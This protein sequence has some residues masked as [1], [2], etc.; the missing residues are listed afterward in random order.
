MARFPAPEGELR[1]KFVRTARGG[2]CLMRRGEQRGFFGPPGEHA[3][4]AATSPPPVT[5]ERSR[6]LD[7]RMAG[8]GT[9]A[10]FGMEGSAKRAAF[11]RLG[12]LA[13]V[14]AAFLLHA[15]PARALAPPT[16]WDGT[17]PFNCVVQ[18]AGL[19]PTG[20]DPS[21]DPYC[22][23]FDKSHQNI[24][25]G[26]I[27]D[28]LL[29][30]P[31]R[32]AA[33]VP[34]CFYYQEDHWRG[35]L[36]QSGAQTVIYEFEGH[37]FFN[38]ATGDGGVWVTGF[39]VA[40]QTFDPTQLP[41]FPPQYGQYFGPGTG[42]FITH[43]EVP[44]D[45]QCVALAQ[46]NPGLY[47]TDVPRCVSG[48]GTLGRHG[49][50]SIELGT[51]EE[52]IRARL[53]PPSSVKRGFLRYCVNGGGSLLVG[54]PGDRSGTFGPAGSGPAVALLTTARAYTLRG[55]HRLTVRV[56]AST[57]IL[58]RAFPRARTI[59]YM[60]GEKVLRLGRGILAAVRR[61]RVAYLAVYDPRAIR[62]LRALR[63]YLRR[64]G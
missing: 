25:E 55:R 3:E 44:A 22:V 14:T 46:R 33:A 26:G 47:R 37:Y 41:G 9:R 39:T 5:L 18:D 50:G 63:S 28:F 36:I 42:G 32:T 59:A 56:G 19:G 20:P 48:G 12:T 31:A 7:I 16:P 35:S 10:A 4:F 21:A 1:G 15:L 58:M 34:K 27:V 11:A 17:S 43:D 38:K 64:A 13:V 53:G 8:S 61:R 52:A 30:E 60:R 49:L 2:L 40:G 51:S 57:R 6:T 23:R 45:P 29:K 24:L 54:V 62:D